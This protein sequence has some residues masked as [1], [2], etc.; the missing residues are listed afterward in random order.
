MKYHLIFS[1]FLSLMY[2][3]SIAQ[4]IPVCIEKLNKK[5]S[6]T[7][8]RFE[9][10]IELKRNRRVYQFSVKSLAQCIDC[11][12]GSIFYDPN[13][14]VVAYFMMGRGASAFVEDGYTAAEFGKAGYPNIRFGSKKNTIPDCIV[15]AISN[16]DSLKQANVSRISQVRIK[17]KILYGFEHQLDPKLA[18]CKDCS[19]SI[20][21]YNDHGRPE[22]T[23]R[24]GGIA[25]IKGENGYTS[26]DFLKKNTLKILWKAN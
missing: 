18:N 8:T 20:V 1:L 9:R 10:A 14:N 25:G 13:C 5:T 19:I 16:I 17:E 2:C 21:Y 23:F 11:N 22:V 15:K 7:T 3:E 24:V 6:L 26:I 4:D 12:N